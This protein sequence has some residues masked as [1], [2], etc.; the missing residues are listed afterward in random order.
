MT[1]DPP[2]LSPPTQ[3][4]STTPQTIPQ[5]NPTNTTTTSTSSTQD[6]ASTPTLTPTTVQHAPSPPKAAGIPESQETSEEYEEPL[7]IALAGPTSSGK[8][9]LAAALTRIF[10]VSHPSSLAASL[11]S[12]SYHKPSDT[13][14]NTLESA[15]EQ[16]LEDEE[17]VSLTVLHMDDFYLPDSRIPRLPSPP[18]ARPSSTTAVSVNE[19]TTSPEKAKEGEDR[20]ATR[21]ERTRDAETEEKEE[22]REEDGVGGQVEEEEAEEGLQDWDTPEAFDIPRY[23]DVMTYI[24]THGGEIPWAKVAHDGLEPG[25]GGGG[26]GGVSGDAD[27]GDDDDQAREGGEEAGKGERTKEKKKKGG[28]ISEA[29]I[30]KMRGDVESWFGGRDGDQNMGIASRSGHL[31]RGEYAEMKT[32]NEPRKRKSRKKRRRKIILVEGLFPF[33]PSPQ[34]P[35]PPSST[36]T[37]TSTSTSELPPPALPPSS[38]PDPPTPQITIP[39]SLFNTHLLL[40]C[41]RHLCKSRRESRAGYVT[42]ET[43]WADPP[44]Y[45]D[46]VVW[47]GWI[48]VWGEQLGG[49]GDGGSSGEES[50]R[51]LDDTG[52]RIRSRE[53]GDGK[54]ATFDGSDSLR[55]NEQLPNTPMNEKYEDEDEANDQVTKDNAL[56]IQIW[57]MN[58]DDDK[59]NTNDSNN[60][61]RDGHGGGV[62]QEDGGGDGKHDLEKALEWMIRRIKESY[63]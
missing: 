63:N 9:T 16:N 26:D 12:S 39:P 61:D 36:S 2:P 52:L 38:K 53:D 8:T 47:P 7:L 5:T 28:L 50:N 10:N 49:G 19:P 59:F 1:L 58:D 6:S 46:D 25:Q 43:F 48:G 55:R 35:A 27:E 41:P 34:P 32:T 44:G 62:E 29:V 56:E 33:L 23:I 15:Y 40:R 31:D 20:K 17:E 13:T 4:P 21:V 3:Q 37:S 30:E 57:D 11:S 60:N 22:G 18:A 14:T 54:I 24:R 45:F 51:G 42:V